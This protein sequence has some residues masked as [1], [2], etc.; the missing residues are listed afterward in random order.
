MQGNTSECIYL[1]AF[2][3]KKLRQSKEKNRTVDRAAVEVLA[4]N[5]LSC[6]SSC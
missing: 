4:G 5:I 1:I 3:E 2:L 6:L